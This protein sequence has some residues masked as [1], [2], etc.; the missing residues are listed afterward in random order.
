M[1]HKIRRRWN[2][3]QENDLRIRSR[4]W[5][6]SYDI[7]TSL[8]KG[9]TRRWILSPFQARNFTL[10]SSSY[11]LSVTSDTLLSTGPNSHPPVVL[12]RYFYKTENK[13]IFSILTK[14]PSCHRR[15]VLINL[16]FKLTFSKSYYSVRLYFSELL[17]QKR[18]WEYFTLCARPISNARPLWSLM[19]LRKT[20]KLWPWSAPFSPKWTDADTCVR[21]KSS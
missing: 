13:I 17:L 19:T 15:G 2:I 9:Q 20:W 16:Y 1:G 14:W 18:R 3:D 8:K 12:L 21:D 5:R 7:I 4:I 6:T 10:P 11:C